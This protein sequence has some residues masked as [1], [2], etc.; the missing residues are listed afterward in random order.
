MRKVSV[1]CLTLF[2][3]AI[4]FANWILRTPSRDSPG[5]SRLLSKPN[6]ALEQRTVYF[7][8]AY[9]SRLG[10]CKPSGLEAQHAEVEVFWQHH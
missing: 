4:T 8:M 7:R 3:T 9:F 10:G 2:P 6:I 5:T 1:A